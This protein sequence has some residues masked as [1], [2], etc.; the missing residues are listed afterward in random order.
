M[1]NRALPTTC[2]LFLLAWNHASPSCIL[3]AV[4]LS[5]LYEQLVNLIPVGGFLVHHRR[6]ETA[7]QPRSISKTA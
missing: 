2:L 6:T 5:L 3:H 7:Q 4:L 1:G